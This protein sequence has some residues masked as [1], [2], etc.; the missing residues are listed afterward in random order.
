MIIILA[1]GAS[2]DGPEATAVLAAARQFPAVS[3][4]VYQRAGKTRTLVEIH[5]LGSTADVPSR[6]F[7]ELPGVERVVR[8]SEKYRLLGR[9]EGK[10]EPVG[11]THHGVRF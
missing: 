9:H 1:R 8:V 6:A 5:L 4:A 7:A 2:V 3:T 11:F 10:L